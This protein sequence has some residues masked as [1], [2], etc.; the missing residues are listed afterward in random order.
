MSPD[1]ATPMV[2]LAGAC[3]AGAP[4]LASTGTTVGAVDGLLHFR[5]DGDGGHVDVVCLPDDAAFD[6][7]LDSIGPILDGAV[8]VVGPEGRSADVEARRFLAYH[9]TLG[10]CPVLLAVAGVGSSRAAQDRLAG[11]DLDLDTPVVAYDAPT[12][13]TAAAVL[14]HA[15]DL[16]G[17]APSA[18]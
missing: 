7:G 3:G 14:A 5:F 15:L 8:F 4:T 12:R 16:A 6:Q 10:Y 11:L 18:R 13:G 9:R 1:P 17:A 2:L